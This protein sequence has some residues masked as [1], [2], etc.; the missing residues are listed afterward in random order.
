MKKPGRH[1]RYLKIFSELF[2][3]NIFIIGLSTLL[4]LVF[5]GID[6]ISNLSIILYQK[7]DI[8][9]CAR[10]NPQNSQSVYS[11]A[12]KCGSATLSVL[13][14][15][16]LNKFIAF[17]AKK[18]TYS[19]NIRRYTYY[20]LNKRYTI[21]NKWI[22]H[23]FIPKII[24]VFLHGK[25]LNY[26]NQVNY[27]K[28]L[29]QFLGVSNSEKHIV[30]IKGKAY[31]GKTTIIFRFIEELTNKKN[32][33]LFEEYEKNIYYFDLG[34]PSLDIG[35][36]HKNICDKK[37]ENA[38][39]IL[40]NIHKVELSD[41]RIFITTLENYHNNVKFIIC[42]SR[43]LDEF[44]F[45]QEICERLSGFINS[46]AEELD[47]NSYHTKTSRIINPE[48]NV[49]DEIMANT[50]SDNDDFNLFCIRLI[51]DNQKIPNALIIQFYNLYQTMHNT[52]NSKFIYD[53]FDMLNTGNGDIY[54]KITLSF[55]IHATLFS[56]GF[57][58]YW[59]YEYI[60]NTEDKK[61]QYLVR[62]HFRALQKSCFISIVCSSNANEVAFH[63]TLAR[64]YF[65]LIDKSDN[66]KSI[67]VSI[68][69]Y[70][71][72]KNINC[73]RFS[74]AWKYKI[75]NPTISKDRILFDKALCTANFKTLLEDLQYI[76]KQ[77]NYREEQFYRELGILTDRF[78]QL[79]K[80]A[81]YIKNQLNSKF[82]PALYINLVQVNHGKFNKK[83]INK[84]MLD[85]NDAYVRIAAKYWKA[86]I[87]LHDGKFNFDNFSQLLTEWT[88]NK[89]LILSNHPYDGL[90]L[91]RRWYFDCFRVYYLAGLF[92]PELLRPIISAKLFEGIINLPEFEAY[93]YKFQYAFFLHY[94]ILF[95]K[96]FF[97]SLDSDKLNVWDDIMLGQGFLNRLESVRDNE[98]SEID[99]IVEEAIGY[100]KASSDGLKKI[101]D[102]SYRYSDLRVWEL[103][104]AY[105][106][107][108]IDDIFNN[109]KFIKDYIQH[110]LSIKIDEYVAYGYTY[111]LKNY[112]VGQY[113]IATEYDDNPRSGGTLK[114]LYITDE[115]IQDCFKNIRLY[116]NRY[117]GQRKNKYCLFRLDI[118][119]VLYDYSH[120]KIEFSST[121]NNLDGLL[122]KARE[123]GYRREELV[124][125]YLL[126]DGMTRYN[127]Y[128]FFKFYPLV[129]Q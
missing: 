90:H 59:F 21:S 96:G 101:M 62:K 34:T 3:N 43:Q 110:S 53:V 33:K 26:N 107:V 73:N 18:K 24:N 65:E 25:P 9:F 116:H 45:S 10:I 76:M 86:H 70:L 55:I 81:N 119:K 49:I 20:E 67:N 36:I 37:Y 38:L 27:I 51:K 13:I 14:S 40:D 93:Q 42:L 100:Y 114:N 112:L 1:I 102:K 32:L 63:E 41:L 44:C 16:I 77:K 78:G 85:M 8:A 47:I 54:L 12:I 28:H 83:T 129:M 126:K 91:M 2:V 5:L 105:E 104:L 74:N 72:D 31:S 29:M 121:K 80:A 52:H 19:S 127:I 95:Q 48:K 57:E 128:K 89:S 23:A 39:L 11:F 125:D 113:S 50:K 106:T 111:L 4:F 15:I 108:K 97:G 22:M 69:R 6:K 66:F 75:L 120:N 46:N 123:R 92:N 124:L 98:E 84:L 61:G 60:Q 58:A 56:G 117:R 71:V 94:D 82:E 109:E 79:D 68:V 99:I 35:L 115:L 88:R 103:K 17:I 64:H 7:I 118:Y 122:K 87:E 30:W